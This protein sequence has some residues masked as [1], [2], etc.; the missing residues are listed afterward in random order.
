[1]H[2]YL[3][4]HALRNVWCS[5]R[6]DNQLVV[7]PKRITPL[8]G[9]LNVVRVMGVVI[10]LPVKKRY[11]H[12]FQI[13]QIDPTTIGLMRQIPHWRLQKW[14]KFSDAVNHANLEVTIYTANGVIAPRTDSYYMFTDERAVIF[15]IP[16]QR[17]RVSTYPLDL[18]QEVY[19]RFYS[20]NYYKSPSPLERVLECGYFTPQNAN[21]ILAM[22]NQLANI[23]ARPGHTFVW[24]NGLLV[25]DALFNDLQMDDYVEWV[26]DRSVKKVVEWS[27]NNVPQFRSKLDN[28]YKFLL[29]YP[30]PSDQTIDFQDD[31][32]IYITH[33]PEQGFTRGV[34]YNRNQESHHRMVTHRDYS[35]ATDPVWSLINGLLELRQIVNIDNQGLKIKAFIREGGMKRKLVQDNNRIFEMY[36]LDDPRPFRA[37]SG[38]DS[39][40]SEWQ[41]ANLEASAY[42]ELMRIPY[43]SVTMELVEKAYGYNAMSVLLGHTPQ[44]MSL[45]S[46]SPVAFL[47]YGLAQ[48]STV[49]EFDADGR[50][51][52]HR[53]HLNDDSYESTSPDCRM[54]EA[55][56]G[57]ASQTLDCV[58]GQTNIPV[59]DR[60]YSYRVYMCY[61]VEGEPNNNWVDITNDEGY[62]QV[63]NGK[64]VWTL[65]GQDHWLMVRTDKKL[66]SMD[67]TLTFNDGLLNFS[68]MENPTGNP[69]D[70]LVPMSVPLAQ[71]DIWLNSYKLI[72]GLD[73][74]VKFPQ[75]FITNKTF[76]VQPT[77]TAEQKIHVRMMGLPESNKV[78][79]NIEETGWILNGQLSDNGIYDLREDRVMQINIGGRLVHRDD[80]LFAEQRPGQSLLNQMNGLPYQIK[81]LIVPLR[82]N[83]ETDT[84]V[85]RRKSQAIDAKIS[86]YMTQ[87]YGQ[88]GTNELSAITAR[89]PVVSPFFSHILF[90]L[91]N[92][93][94]Q[95]P[96]ERLL[97]DQEVRAICQVHE[98]L[99][100]FDPLLNENTPDKNFAYIVPH[101]DENPITLD[102]QGYRFLTQ[103]VKIYG[104]DKIQVSD[105]VNMQA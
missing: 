69:I 12:V 92:R 46:G 65:G 25:D 86:A 10:D 20:N 88:M 64:I 68:M 8:R 76:L 101:P 36:K 26:Y 15:A 2:Q 5:P 52:G 3:V 44:K 61:L 13:G 96:E 75:I 45:A 66:L 18:Q 77:E 73:Y 32:D 19:F 85:L 62:Y 67:L 11:T 80:L 102:F 47:P 54:I 94:I 27:L 40:V 63:V 16:E 87:M 50:L 59:P 55:V 37:M 51:L 99:L 14:F 79:D 33:K 38:L 72:R 48:K 89:Y 28:V 70:D 29:H 17:R 104:D 78:L 49:Y 24:V 1:M 74:F 83:T 100:D 23:K 34:Y 21:E 31:V 30:G 97:L 56:S 57:I 53:V 39:T 41:A 91:R 71:L 82:T 35:I 42:A 98:G 43:K 9:S 90:L 81:D 4:D 93:L 103:V 58:Y 6:Q 22:E 95:L 7:A 105:Y 84:Y 60:Q